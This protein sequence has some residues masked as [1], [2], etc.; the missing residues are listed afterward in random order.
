MENLQ[1]VEKKIF[2][3]S[4]SLHSESLLGEKPFP[5]SILSTLKIIPEKP[6]G[7]KPRAKGAIFRYKSPNRDD[8]GGFS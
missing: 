5:V 2:G 8:F 6:I 7:K 3:L 1:L 4:R